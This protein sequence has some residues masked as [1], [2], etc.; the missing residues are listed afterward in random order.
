[1][2]HAQPSPL[3]TCSECS[4][5]IPDDT[6]TCSHCG[7]PVEIIATSEAPAVTVHPIEAFTPAPERFEPVKEGEGTPRLWNPTTLA[8]LTLPILGPVIGSILIGLNWNYLKR[9]NLAILA[10][11]FYPAWIL[12]AMTMPLPANQTLVSVIAYGLW[13][14]VLG[15]P[16]IRYF[17]KHFPTGHP[18]RSWAIPV[19]A[20]LGLMAAQI[21]LTLQ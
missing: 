6:T 3:M 13:F 7:A 10:W 9:R 12:V 21:F 2:S 1:M 4:N 16:Q 5:Q 15:L 14:V 19:L 20:G 8:Y 11:G 18:K 17:Q